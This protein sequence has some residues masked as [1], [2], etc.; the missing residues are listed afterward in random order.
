[1]CSDVL[2]EFQ[3]YLHV[4]SQLYDAIIPYLSFKI[5]KKFKNKKD[6]ENFLRSFLGNIFYNWKSVSLQKTLISLRSNDFVKNEKWNIITHSTYVTVS[7]TV[8][9]LEEKGL[10]TV[11]RGQWFG[12]KNKENTM[13]TI[14]PTEKLITI[15]KQYKDIEPEECCIVAK[16]K[17]DDKGLSKSIYIS[18]FPKKIETRKEIVDSFNLMMKDYIIETEEKERLNCKLYAIYNNVNTHQGKNFNLGGRFYCRGRSHQQMSKEERGM[19]TINN[20]PL[21][22][23]DYKCLHIYLLYTMYNI[24]F[25]GDAYDFISPELRPLAKTLLLTSINCT[26]KGQAVSS[27]NYN[28]DDFDENLKSLYCQQKD[29]WSCLYDKMVSRH[30]IIKDSF[31]NQERVVP[32][33]MQLQNGDSYLMLQLLKKSFEENFPILPVHDSILCYNSKESFWRDYMLKIYNEYTNFN[34]IVEKA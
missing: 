21:I 31:I 34:I 18:K 1:M 3:R 7:S 2:F 8:K 5:R 29:N 27:L 33:G 20:N 11:E 22:E 6:P 10:I 19:L 12:A 16:T 4:E 30:L 24:Q 26:N 13:T 14:S 25:Y 23:L 28:F 9:D 17:K 15:F 32:I